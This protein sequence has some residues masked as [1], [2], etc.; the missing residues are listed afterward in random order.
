MKPTI[1]KIAHET[2]AKE[3]LQHIA[4]GAQSAAMNAA[5]KA[6]S[7]A[8][9]AHDAATEAMNANGSGQKVKETLQ[10]IVSGAQSTAINVADKTK[11]A[12][13]KAQTTVVEAIDANGNGQIDVEDFIIHGLRLP[14][15][16][17][18]RESFLRKEFVK[19][20]PSQTIE[21]AVARTPASAGI[22][23]EDVDKIADE[24]IKFERNCVTSI[25]AALGMPGGAT[26]AAT[27]PA[28]I[29]QYYGYLLRAMQKLMYLYGF[30]QINLT[31]KNQQFDA[32]TMNLLILGLGTMYGVVGA[33]N[34]LKVAA[35]ALG[36]G[37][38]KKLMHAAL[39]KGTVYPVVKSIA[40]WFNVKMTKEVFAGFFKK[41]I[42]VVGGAIGGGM[43]YM[44]F[45]PCCDRLKESLRDTLLS[46]PQQHDSEQEDVV[47]VEYEVK[48]E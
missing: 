10:H 30:P 12:A 9:K 15:V 37:V 14:W 2:N 45:K 44:S 19:K 27:I 36:S 28:D 1:P 20:Y 3:M 29:I 25:S 33:N 48:D 46:N 38:E 22:P 5:G 42:P 40:K 8:G 7:A 24:V 31:E 32:E 23:R 6:K 21:E 18:N 47:E 39:T 16:H 13:T 43:T 11:A 26:V 17:V 4:S 41:A 34:A 35:R